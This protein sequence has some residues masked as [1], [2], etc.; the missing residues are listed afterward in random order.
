V[1]TPPSELR[2]TERRNPRSAD[3]DLASPLEIVD[4][5]NAEDALVPAAVAARAQ[6]LRIDA[7]R[8]PTVWLSAGPGYEQFGRDVYDGR[9]QSV[10]RFGNGFQYRASI[11]KTISNQSAIGVAATYGRMPLRYYALGPAT[12]NIDGAPTSACGAGNGCRAHA[13]VGSL[14]VT[15][16]V[17]GGART[18][19]FQVIEGT[20]GV[21]RYAN[22]RED[23]SDATLGPDA[24]L[25]ASLT[26]GYGVGYTLSR[27]VQISLVQDYSTVLHERTGLPSGQ[28]ALGQMYTTR[29]SVRLG[30]GSRRPGV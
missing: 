4:L 7:A 9:T 14:G 15:F 17:G 26:V 18:G 25:D 8:E 10:W 30:A 23:A 2:V 19:I 28:S 20:A 11:E 13:Q 5:M 3:V 22:F 6:I 29:L 12:P 21:T 16:H 1:P 24:N 27:A